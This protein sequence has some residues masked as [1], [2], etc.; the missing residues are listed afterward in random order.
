MAKI[1]ALKS[2]ETDIEST[3]IWRFAFHSDYPTFKIATAGTQDVTIL[4]GTSEIY[5]DITHGLGYKPIFFAFLKYGIETIPIFGDG[6]GIFDTGILDEH[7]DP[8]SIITYQ[9]LSDTK[10]RLGL[11]SAPYNLLNNT[12]FTLSWI[13]A[14]DEF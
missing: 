4:A 11:Y 2:G 8:T 9:T 12:T 6:S 13:I 3:D 1:K 7:G 5:L 14:L 10:L